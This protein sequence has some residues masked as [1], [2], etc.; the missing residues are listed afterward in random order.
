MIIMG[1]YG[2]SGEDD[3]DDTSNPAETGCYD[4]KNIFDLAGNIYDWTLEADYTDYRVIRRRPL[5][6][7]T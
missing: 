7:Y 2:V 6:Q 1:N 4:V 3:Y 5:L